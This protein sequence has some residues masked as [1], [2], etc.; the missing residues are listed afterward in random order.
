MIVALIIAIGC[1][2]MAIVQVIYL[3]FGLKQ[4]RRILEEANHHLSE[5]ARNLG[6]RPFVPMDGEKIQTR[7]VINDKWDEE[8]IPTD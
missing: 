3:Q 5:I 4:H 1:V 6:G 2:A 7:V 8:R